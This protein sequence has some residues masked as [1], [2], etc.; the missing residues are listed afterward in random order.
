[1]LQVDVQD[2][3][4]SP[5]IAPGRDLRIR[6]RRAIHKPFQH[7]HAH[8][9]KSGCLD[10]RQLVV[11][12]RD[13]AEHRSEIIAGAADPALWG[14]AVCASR[15]ASRRTPDVW[16]GAHSGTEVELV[17]RLRCVR[18]SR[19]LARFSGRVDVMEKS[20]HKD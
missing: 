2:T 12:V 7:A 15:S 1:V 9:W 19:S 6:P 13:E 16:T 3:A 14:C 11:S 20:T 17:F 4:D 18:D 5:T 8:R 10:E